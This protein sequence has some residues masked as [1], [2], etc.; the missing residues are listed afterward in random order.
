M[1]HKWPP[2]VE[3]IHT[4][5]HSFSLNISSHLNNAKSDIALESI[6]MKSLYLCTPFFN[7]WNWDAM[8]RRKRYQ[9]GKM[10]RNYS[11]FK[12]HMLSMEIFW[13]FFVL[14]KAFLAQTH[15]PKHTDTHGSI[16]S[17]THK[18]NLNAT[19]HQNCC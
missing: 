17:H 9:T 16:H 2:F 1:L 5:T 6:C 12:Y 7:E 11:S 4:Y 14:Q 3:N 15:T 8:K 18:L 10:F 19:I 13:F